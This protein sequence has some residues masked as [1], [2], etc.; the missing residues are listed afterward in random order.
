ME[1][2][3]S[4]KRTGRNR[5]EEMQELSSDFV[6]YLRTTGQTLGSNNTPLDILQGDMK[7]REGFEGFQ[8][9][10]NY[11]LDGC[12]LS[13]NNNTTAI[14]TTSEVYA[15]Q[16]T[17][18]ETMGLLRQ[19]RAGQWTR[20]HDKYLIMKKL[21]DG[22][23]ERPYT[24][25]IPDE[26]NMNKALELQEAKARI[27]A[28]LSNYITEIARI[29]GVSKQEAKHILEENIKINKDIFSQTKEMRVEEEEPQ[30]SKEDRHD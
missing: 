29:H 25:S 4:G 10:I 2:H 16:R 9:V 20:I 26:E 5:S 19:L 21:W 3:E 28:N 12:G 24:I 13:P 14:K 1:S 30:A 23:G 7:I 18:A 6:Y 27:E 11:I 15:D 22:K 17:S 8:E